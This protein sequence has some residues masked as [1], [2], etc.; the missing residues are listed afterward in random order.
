MTDVAVSLLEIEQREVFGMLNT[1]KF[2]AF[3][4]GHVLQ[5]KKNS[6]FVTAVKHVDM[7]G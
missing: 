7:K 4:G 5:N 6:M 1:E 2:A 3:I